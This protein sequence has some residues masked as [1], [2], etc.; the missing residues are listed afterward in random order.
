MAED[1]KNKP[2]VD[3]DCRRVIRKKIKNE[4]LIILGVN[5]QS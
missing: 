2:E 1:E 5:S 3:K 4:L